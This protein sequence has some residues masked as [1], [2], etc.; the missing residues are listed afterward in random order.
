MFKKLMKSNI[1]ES[2]MFASHFSWICNAS[3]KHDSRTKMY[4]KLDF[5]GYSL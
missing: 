1:K 5:N 3:A 2:E 4:Q